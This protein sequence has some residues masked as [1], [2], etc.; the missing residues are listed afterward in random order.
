MQTADESSSCSYYSSTVPGMTP[1]QMCNVSSGG[2]S[3]KSNPN[4]LSPMV[5]Q[6]SVRTL[7]AEQISKYRHL[8][9]PRFGQPQQQQQ[10]VTDG[11]RNAGL[12]SARP[13]EVDATSA[14]QFRAP[15]NL[16]ASAVPAAAN[17]MRQ[18]RTQQ[19]TA[20]SQTMQWPMNRRVSVDVNQSDSSNSSESN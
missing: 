14:F 17:Y 7:S 18:L 9:P 3:L 12:I 10:S 15:F 1:F 4:I 2:S 5:C 13:T 8:L 16:T 20:T 6:G 19:L 11:Q